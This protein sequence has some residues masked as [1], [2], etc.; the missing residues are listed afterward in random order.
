MPL[1]AN[2]GWGLKAGQMTPY[3]MRAI[4]VTRALMND[5]YRDLAYCTHANAK[6]Y[7][8]RDLAYSFFEALHKVIPTKSFGSLGSNFSN[9]LRTPIFDNDNN[10]LP[11]FCGTVRAL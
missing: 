4:T 3:Q 1:I 7:T 2:L 11:I 6:K 5:I 9:F 10:D 8:Y